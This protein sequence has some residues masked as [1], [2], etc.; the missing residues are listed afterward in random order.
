MFSLQTIQLTKRYPL[1]HSW[2]SFFHP[3]Q[4]GP[5]VVD[6]V[7]LAVHPGELFGLLGPNGA[8]KTTLVKMLATLVQP[9]SGQAWVNGYPLSNESA[10]K[11][12]IGLAT[13]DERSFYWRLSGRQNLDFFASLHGLSGADRR[14]QVDQVLEAVDLVNAANTRFALYST[15]MRQRLSIAR[16][17][18]NRPTLLFLD[19]PGRGLDPNSARRLHS[20]VRSLAEQGVTI[21][22]TTHDLAEAEALCS[23][24]AI[25]HE[26][27]LRACGS[28]GEL[29]RQFEQ[30]GALPL[31][32]GDRYL[33]Q[34]DHLPEELL[35]CLQALPAEPHRLP[36]PAAPEITLRAVEGDGR[37]DAVLDVLR[38]GRVSVRSITRAPV[39]L[40][41]VFQFFTE[42]NSSSSAPASSSAPMVPEPAPQTPPPSTALP[43]GNAA[44][45]VRVAGAFLRRDLITNLS[46]R[47]SFAFQL[48]SVF[49]SIAVFYFISQLFG[50][51]AAPY[52][53]PYGGDYFAFVLLGIAF[54]GYFG[55]G[56]SSFADSLQRAQSTGTLEAMLTTP[57][58]LS[59]L[60]LSSSL[61]DYLMTTLRV[62]VYLGLGAGF[63]GVNL[64]N[65][66]LVGAGLVLIL[67]ILVFSSLGILAASF[68]MVLK[69]GNPV[70]WAVNTFSS[71]LGG[72]Y[73]P[74]AVLPAVLQAL[75]A[76]LPITYALNALRLALLQGASISEL[77]PDLLALGAF[78]V[79]LLPAS[80]LS[81]RWAVRRARIEGSLTQY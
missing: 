53:E 67:T 5:P 64:A 61:W 68:V 27:Q 8:G 10:I 23:R 65:S 48:I 39:P 9:T 21:F 20:L 37:L 15:G 63:L 6:R 77:A 7:N 40:E 2:S 1:Q 29:R 76:L 26:G 46:Y 16:A 31:A 66:N 45:F 58:R 73:Y 56:L 34:V 74:V 52:L 35:P 36:P 4:S 44:H 47:V 25:L 72:V 55:V 50:Q 59:S 11:A 79:V 18:L 71:L 13:G 62:L 17:L 12:S 69:R 60:L 75:A 19:E 28:A 81:F 78:G 3:G 41:E 22:L 24:I 32:A 33:I 80:L 30:Q 43:T 51:A 70:T 42:G 49:F 38:Q 57:S 14:R 54:A